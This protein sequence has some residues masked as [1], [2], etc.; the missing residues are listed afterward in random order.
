MQY[1]YPLPC[2]HC[3]LS[4]AQIQN[5]SLVIDSRHGGQLHT[6]VISLPSLHLILAHS[7]Q[8]DIDPLQCRIP[9]CGRPWG[10]I[11]RGR[12][13][14]HVWHAR[15]HHQNTLSFQG[16]EMLLSAVPVPQKM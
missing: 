5:G 16:V 3:E 13:F 9:G 10:M 6:N 2:V 14:C 7:L 11:Q 1:T 4:W 15:D 8:H 12:L